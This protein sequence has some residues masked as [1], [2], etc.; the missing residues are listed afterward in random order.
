[1]ASP[2]LVVFDLDFTLWDCGGLWVDCAAHPFRKNSQ[3]QV[4]DS[5][6]RVLKLYEDV[7]SILDWVDD[8]NLPMGL[9]SRT[10]QP[11]W[12]CNLLDLFAIRERFQFA[13]IYP[14]SKTTHFERL[15]ED[16][17]FDFTEMIFFDDESRNIAEVGALGVRSVQVCRGMSHHLFHSAMKKFP[18]VSFG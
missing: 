13:E 18:D 15:R 4:I 5:A 12:A 11:A 16:S 7:K 10:E 8:R 17:G 1:M 3:G 6:G 2:Q 14:G 9:A